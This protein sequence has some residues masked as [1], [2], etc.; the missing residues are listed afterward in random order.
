M[1]VMNS[2]VSID[3]LSLNWVKTPFIK[4]LYKIIK[5]SIS[6]FGDQNRYDEF[7]TKKIFKEIHMIAQE[8][9]HLLTKE[10]PIKENYDQT[11]SDLVIK[12]QNHDRLKSSIHNNQGLMMFLSVSEKSNPEM[13]IK[14]LNYIKDCFQ[15]AIKL[16]ENNYSALLNNELL[17][18]YVGDIKDEE[19]LEFL[20]GKLKRKDPASARL[21]FSIF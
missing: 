10:D 21:M 3:S 18:W 16:S 8:C 6:P 12:T 13:R 4:A 17:K 20:N 1:R 14:T 19:M 9:Y 11:L 2:E 7:D 5:M 15:K